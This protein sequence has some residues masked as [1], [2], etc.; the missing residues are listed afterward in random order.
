[1]MDTIELIGTISVVFLPAVTAAAVAV[2]REVR[3]HAPNGKLTALE[4]RMR[5]LEQ[6][7][8]RVFDH[9]LG[10]DSVIPDADLDAEAS[11]EF[12]VSDGK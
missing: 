6:R 1:M 7:M 8:A 10:S 3:K 11:G 9:I 5:R 4:S 12:G 2:I